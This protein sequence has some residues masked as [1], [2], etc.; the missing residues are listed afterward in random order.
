MTTAPRPHDVAR[1][2]WQ[3]KIVEAYR[4]GDRICD[5]SAAFACASSYPT[6]LARRRGLPIRKP[7]CARAAR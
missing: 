6:I 5:I 2:E 3:D 7:E 1:R 4:R